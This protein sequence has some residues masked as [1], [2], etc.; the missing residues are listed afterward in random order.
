MDVVEEQKS[1][2]KHSARSSTSRKVSHKVS[3]KVT[4]PMVIDED[5]E[6][7]LAEDSPPDA[8]HLA[9]APRQ[10]TSISPARRPVVEIPVPA[11]RQSDLQVESPQKVM[12]LI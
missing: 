5:E 4:A 8:R 2:A 3:S 1:S 10:S 11:R 9:P 12:M 6:D 7:E